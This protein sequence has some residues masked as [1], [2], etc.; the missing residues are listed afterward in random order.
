MRRLASCELLQETQIVLRKEANI[1]NIEQN[2]RQSV[3]P[4]T[5]SKSGPFFR[6]VTAV[7]AGLVDRFENGRMH[8]SAAA[9]FDPLFAAFE[10]ACFYV[11]FKTRFGVWKF[12]RNI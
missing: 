1:G 3:H 5:E 2:H 6:I 10:R 9:D 11:N 4:K 7:A 12:M 8:H